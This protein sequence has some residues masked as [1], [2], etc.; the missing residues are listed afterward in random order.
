MDEIYASIIEFV[1]A[2]SSYES[3]VIMNDV[4][5]KIKQA[6]S[7]EDIF[8]IPIIERVFNCTTALQWSYFICFTIDY[9]RKGSI[10]NAS[11]STAFN[12]ENATMF[13]SN[14]YDLYNKE[15]YHEYFDVDRD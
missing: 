13:I 7:M 10:S 9:M 8:K 2:N 1:T 14:T 6:T 5:S 12:I 15:I 3:S 11:F 4:S